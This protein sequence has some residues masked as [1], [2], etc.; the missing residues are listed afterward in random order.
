[1]RRVTDRAM[2]VEARQGRERVADRLPLHNYTCRQWKQ[3][4]KLE[5]RDT[6]SSEQLSSAISQ[7]ILIL[8]FYRF[9]TFHVLC[10][11]G[12]STSMSKSAGGE[13]TRPTH[14]A[15]L[16]PSHVRRVNRNLLAA[17][18]FVWAIVNSCIDIAIS[19]VCSSSTSISLGC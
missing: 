4:N 15:E 13:K 6:D 7:D 11:C 3:D 10:L 17:T 19:P 2:V 18:V 1:M 9:P 5:A 16:S 14:K 12:V 8:F